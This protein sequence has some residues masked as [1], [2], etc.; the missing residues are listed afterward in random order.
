MKTSHFISLLL[1]FV[2]SACKNFSDEEII[3]KT[4]KK[5]NSIQTIEYVGNYEFNDDRTGMKGEL[6]ENSYFDFRSNDTLIGA[7]YILA[8]SGDGTSKM[9]YFDGKSIIEVDDTRKEIIKNDNPRFY[10]VNSLVFI[11][12]SIAK[13]RQALPLIQG[14]SAVTFTR[15]N[16]TIINN[17]KSYYFKI[18][19]KS[20]H[21]GLDSI[22]QRGSGSSEYTSRYNLAIAKS[23]FLPT[24]FESVNTYQYI[25]NTFSQIKLNNFKDDSVWSD[26]ENY[27]EEYIRLSQQDWVERMRNRGKMYEGSKA[28]DWTLQDLQDNAVTLSDLNINHKLLMFWFPGC[29]PCLQAVP[30]LNE[31]EKNY[32]RKG[33]KIYAIEFTN[34]KKEFIENY[35]KEKDVAYSVLYN[36]KET[37]NQYGVTGAPTFYLIDKTGT[38]TYF[39][40]GLNEKELIT[41]VEKL[42]SGI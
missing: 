9:L 29:V 38:I 34:V 3:S 23:T 13:L 24:Q 16:D 26:Y 28:I 27:S 30:V 35:V 4:I 15:L 33:L 5:L 21:L 19:M 20:M 12:R 31:L 10:H 1:L 6:I 7:K 18:E 11:W 8:Y 42:L 37:A 25:K 41:S 32:A 17:V 36:G 14:D 22:I 39:Q 2:F 40:V